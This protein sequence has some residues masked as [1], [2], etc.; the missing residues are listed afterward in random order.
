M[1]GEYKRL[2]AFLGR[3]AEASRGS[4]RQAVSTLMADLDSLAYKL[5]RARR[6]KERI[7]IAGKRR[8]AGLERQMMALRDECERVKR[9]RDRANARLSV[10]ESERGKAWANGF[11]AGERHGYGER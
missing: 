1:P 5:D 4:Q 10:A 2:S 6:D 3:C 9:E 8:Q 11:A 7:R